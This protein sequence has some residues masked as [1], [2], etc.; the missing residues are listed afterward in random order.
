MRKSYVKPTIYTEEFVPN[1]RIASCG[2][3]VVGNGSVVWECVDYQD[4]KPKCSGNSE[5][6]NQ[7]VKLQDARIF[8]SSAS[9]N[10]IASDFNTLLIILEQI[11]GW[12][13][14]EIN[15][16]K[17]AWAVAENASGNH[18]IDIEGIRF[19]DD[20]FKS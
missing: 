16:P 20:P 4:Q 8:T 3:N 18:V 12:K 13:Y 14:Q 9:C 6:N 19:Y 2:T 15:Q 10:T 11:T 1:Q 5:H 7:L 17:G